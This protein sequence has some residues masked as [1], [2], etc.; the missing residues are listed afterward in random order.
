MDIE[1]LFFIRYN[2]MPFSTIL[3]H[4]FINTVH[5][6][7]LPVIAA[8]RNKY[9]H[10]WNMIEE[11][12][13][14]NSLI[15][16]NKYTI[17]N[18]RNTLDELIDKNYKIYTTNPLRHANQLTNLIHQK[19]TDESDRKTIRLKTIQ[20]QEE[21]VIE[22]DTRQVAFIYKIQKHKSVE[23]INIIKPVEIER[24]YYMPAEIE[25]IDVY[26]DLYTFKDGLYDIEKDLY[27]QVAERKETGVLGGD[28]IHEFG[29]DATHE[30]GLDATQSPFIENQLE[31]HDVVHQDESH[32]VI[33]QDESHDVMHQDES[34]EDTDINAQL[35]FVDMQGYNSDDAQ[36][37]ELSDDMQELESFDDPQEPEPSD[38][39]QV[40]ES[41]YISTEYHGGRQ[42]RNNS[43]RRDAQH[44]SQPPRHSQQ[45]SHQHSHQHSQQH[46]SRPCIERK[47][48]FLE[49]AKLAIVKNWLPDQKDIILLGPWAYNWILLGENICTNIE[50]IQLI[51]VNTP[52]EF[53]YRMQKYFD[54]F[55][56]FVI[57][58]R[59]QELHIPKDFRTT[60]YTFYFKVGSEKTS[61]DKPFLDLFNCANFEIIPYQ[62]HKSINIASNY[63]ILRFLFID[64]WI[65]RVIKNLGLLSA[66]ILNKKIVYLWKLI[67]YYRDNISTEKPSGFIGIHREAS[68]DKKL[69]ARNQAKKYY[70]YYPDI[71]WRNHNA[72]R[73]L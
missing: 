19:T 43:K 65:I 17:L 6:K 35:E 9:S 2:I 14:N 10:V 39:M 53:L 20:D 18:L 15:I 54:T 5:E 50:K 12:C 29:L 71:Y 40:S 8:D 49:S 13:A 52:D 33:Y 60:R 28:A 46:N 41:P 21:F 7:A 26:H 58:Y 38:D 24:V 25:L 37:P 31:S 22:Y 27:E 23:P 3:D 64:L 11:Y 59:E 57:S 44:T 42:R 72:Y 36:E 67:E 73:V 48:D 32:D 16:S 61:V 63:V 55:G 69:L 47:K 66:D 4:K 51:A 30:F 62:I 34:P 56:K 68:I 1:L 45:P 70:P